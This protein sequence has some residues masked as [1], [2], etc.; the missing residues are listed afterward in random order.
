[1]PIVV[2]LW[3]SVIYKK[4][5]ALKNKASRCGAGGIRII[6]VH[7]PPLSIVSSCP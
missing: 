5:E 4:A 3:Y 7:P 1:M 2:R 6:K